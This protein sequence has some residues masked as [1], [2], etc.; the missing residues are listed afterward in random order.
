[1]KSSIKIYIAVFA[2][3]MI[4]ALCDKESKLFILTL[5]KKGL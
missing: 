1:M 2:I 3:I 4:N 5:S